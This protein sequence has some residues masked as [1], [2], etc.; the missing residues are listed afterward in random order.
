MQDND[1]IDALEA[2]KMRRQGRRAF[3]QAA[4]GAAAVGAG[5]AFATAADAQTVGDPD[6]L[7][8]A[9]NLEYLEANFYY[10]A[11][12][13]TPIP[14]ASFG[15][16][17]VNPV[18][19]T[20][21]LAA[22]ATNGNTSVT[23][24]RNARAVT[25]QDPIVQQFAREIANDELTHVN[26]LRRTL[27]AAAVAQP[28][29]DLGTDPVGAFSTAARAANLIPTSGT[30]TTGTGATATTTKNPETSFFDP[31]V[32]DLTF[33]YAAFIF[34]DVGV[35]AYKGASPLITSKAYLDA[36]AGILAVEAHHAAI[37][38]GE[39]DRRG[40]G[41]SVK[42]STVADAYAATVRGDTERTSN[43]R[44]SLDGTA[45]L[46]QGVQRSTTGVGITANIVPT[47]SDA[48][49]FS[50][51]AAQTL[52]IVYLNNK[53]VSAGGFFPNGVNGTIKASAAN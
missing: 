41:A 31:Y 40:D 6:I 5:F 49:V 44:D 26:F 28:L 42:T 10:Y 19:T 16:G 35:S 36:A 47:D 11:V 29:L 1:L 21:T 2:H 20:A 7:N 9:L 23:Y 15:T 46:D 22:S 25:F 33:L 27:G 24:N 14:T 38:R 52:N 4:V 37:I 51:S 39:L 30:T 3:F 18:A 12:Y 53:Q 34:E 43:A 50:R 13:G 48:I 32:N 8:F 17:G 45:D